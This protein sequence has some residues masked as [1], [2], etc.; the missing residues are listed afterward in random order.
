[1]FEAQCVV[2]FR[3]VDSSS[4]SQ[5][6]EKLLE[7]SKS[8]Q[9]YSVELVDLLEQYVTEQVENSWIDIDANFTLLRLY[10]IY[11]DR[12]NASHCLKILIKSLMVAPESHFVGTVSLLPASIRE[13]TYTFNRLTINTF[14]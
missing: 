14:L 2:E 8:N 4:R 1:M 6:Q 11:N 9:L 10:L 12:V 5:I 7:I 3:N 13:V